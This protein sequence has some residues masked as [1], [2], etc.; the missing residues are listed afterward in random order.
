MRKPYSKIEIFDPDRIQR[1]VGGVAHELRFENDL[2]NGNS[3]GTVISLTDA[4]LDALV[5]AIAER[6]GSAT[7][8]TL[9]YRGDG[10]DS[11]TGGY[12]TA[13][14]AADALQTTRAG[15]RANPDSILEPARMRATRRRSIHTERDEEW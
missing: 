7:Y 15:I 4:D 3:S 13:E 11:W 12:P 5:E 8:W 2:G 14:E 10:P 6:R 1:E 9:T